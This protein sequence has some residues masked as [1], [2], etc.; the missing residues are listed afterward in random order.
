MG[1]LLMVASVFVLYNLSQ[2]YQ[3]ALI[4]NQ[5]LNLINAEELKL[6]E[7]IM[8]MNEAA[9]LD[10]KDTYFRNLSQAFLLKINQVLNDEELTEEDKK[11]VF[12]LLVSN[13]ENSANNAVLLNPKNSQNWLQLGRVY[14]NFMAL[15]VEGAE[16]LVISNYQ[17]VEQLSPQNPEIP[18][19]LAR[20]YK[21]QAER[22]QVQIA[23]LEQ[24]EER[25]EGAVEKLKEENDK[26]LETAL[27][28]LEKSAQLKIDFTPTYYLTAQICELKGEKDLALENYKI[29]LLLEPEN[30]E[31]IEK[32]KELTEQ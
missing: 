17:K 5:G 25:D 24:V 9:M 16:S 18:F 3:S 8:K 14:E 20:I 10:K 1:V 30:E 12:Q 31:V 28:K 27:Q 26:I 13:T 19:M 7:G 32:I 23:L 21:T 11:Q 22:I 6:D 4:F 15:G 2:K 29:V